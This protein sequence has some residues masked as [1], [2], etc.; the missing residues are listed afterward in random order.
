MVKPLIDLTGTFTHY[1]ATAYLKDGEE[2]GG[3]REYLVRLPPTDPEN[4]NDRGEP[5]IRCH[6]ET[7]LALVHQ[8]FN[9]DLSK[10]EDTQMQQILW[11]LSGR[12]M[13]RRVFNED[14]YESGRECMGYE[15]V[16]LPGGAFAQIHAALESSGNHG[17]AALMREGRVDKE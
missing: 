1:R 13:S 6:S 15:L 2:H 17:L 7:Q 8:G 3:E 11:H 14:F 9:L 16:W 10:D 5:V 4:R 12:L